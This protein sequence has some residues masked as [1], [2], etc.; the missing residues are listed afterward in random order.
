MSSRKS[1]RG[2]KLGSS[3]RNKNHNQETEEKDNDDGYQDPGKEEHE[4]ECQFLTV[5]EN[6]S[7]NKS[8]LLHPDQPVVV[9]TSPSSS[10]LEFSPQP[11][12]QEFNVVLGQADITSKKRKMGSTRKGNRN[13]K[14]EE[15]S[16]DEPEHR[17]QLSEGFSDE[18]KVDEEASIKEYGGKEDQTSLMDCLHSQSSESL[19]SV[20]QGKHFGPDTIMQNEDDSKNDK[21]QHLEAAVKSKPTDIFSSEPNQPKEAEFSQDLKHDQSSL[22]VMV[23]DTLEGSHAEDIVQDKVTGVQSASLIYEHEHMTEDDKMSTVKWENVNSK[24]STEDEKTVEHS[25]EHKD[26]PLQLTEESIYKSES[27]EVR[28]DTDEYKENLN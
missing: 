6:Q 20:L 13:F 1:K 23:N 28:E 2:Q 22:N 26:K 27:T 17:V 24:A 18:H 9:C 15:I 4:S 21:Y 11:Q 8:S 10:V 14:F 7:S 19:S 12:S 3:R 25:L 16:E 5:S